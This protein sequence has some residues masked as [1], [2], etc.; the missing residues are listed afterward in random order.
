MLATATLAQY[1]AFLLAYFALVRRARAGSE[2]PTQAQKQRI[3]Y[4]LVQY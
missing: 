2:M 4:R 1:I 3:V